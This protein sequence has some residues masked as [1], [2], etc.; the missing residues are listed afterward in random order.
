ML[1]DEG[2][3]LVLVEDEKQGVNSHFDLGTRAKTDV[4]VL[5]SGRH[6][7]WYGK[8]IVKRLDCEIGCRVENVV[9]C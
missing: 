7:G 4:G 8:K 5:G 2:A 3:E 1:L 9:C 6:L